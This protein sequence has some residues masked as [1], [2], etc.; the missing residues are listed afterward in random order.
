M[1]KPQ[2]ANRKLQTA[3]ILEIFSSIQGEGPRVGERQIFIRFNNCNLN[4]NYC[5]VPRN[6]KPA[7]LSVKEIISKIRRLN[8]GAGHKTV[9]LTGG[10]PLLQVEFLK[11]LLPELKRQKY[12]IYLETNATL[13]EGLKK[14]LKFVD[15][16]SADMKLPSVTK[17]KPHWSKHANFIRI[18]HNK[19]I[20]IKTVVSRKLKMDDFKKAVSLLKKINPKTPFIIQPAMNG[21]KMQISTKR[22]FKLQSYALGSLKT[23]LIIPQMHKI[24]GL[25]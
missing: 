2:T 12:R 25:R 14:I 22:L 19:D 16:I 18:A 4:C 10:E 8:N 21:K 11:K 7:N 3:D 1:N 13:P 9:S 17:E 20:F 24:L 23:S 6:I 15:I 5:D